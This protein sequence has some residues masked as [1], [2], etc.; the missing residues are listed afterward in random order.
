MG[1]V[2]H[3]QAPA[4]PAMEATD[5]RP[6]A[7]CEILFFTGVRYERHVEPQQDPQTPAAPTRRRARRRSA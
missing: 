5:Q 4:R 6:G 3:F 1:R 2:L 7:M